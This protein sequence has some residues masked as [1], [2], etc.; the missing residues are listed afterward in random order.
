MQRGLFYLMTRYKDIT[1]KSGVRAYRIGADYIEIKFKTGETYVYNY[2]RPG[3]LYVE[4]M[5]RLA[6]KGR[7]LS[8]FISRKVRERFCRKLD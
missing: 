4:Q 8:T 2:V 5:K 1:G 6:E 7:G 3:R